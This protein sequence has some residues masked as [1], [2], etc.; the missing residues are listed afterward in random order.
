MKLLKV[1]TSDVPIPHF[2]PIPILLPIPA[3]RADTDTADTPD[4]FYLLSTINKS[5]C[6][7]HKRMYLVNLAFY[8]ILNFF[9]GIYLSLFITILLQICKES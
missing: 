8:C 2:Q 3:F 7:Q 1:V 9:L 6:K 4:T 5:L